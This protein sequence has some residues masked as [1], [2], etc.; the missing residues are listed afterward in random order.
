MLVVDRAAGRF[1]DRLFSDFPEYLRAG[2]CLV[3]NDTRVFP[4]RLHGRRNHPAGAAVE[5][6]L[7]RALNA[8]ERR[9]RLLARPAK[10]VRR[11]DRIL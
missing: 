9:W 7:V 8:Q 11:G 1:D 4:A 3:L 10:R 6:F 2:D 5:L